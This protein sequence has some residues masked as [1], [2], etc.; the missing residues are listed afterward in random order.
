MQLDSI[1]FDVQP[2]KTDSL[3]EILSAL[4][5]DAVQRGICDDNFTA[6]DLFDTKLM[7]VFTPFPST[8]RKQFARLYSDSPV[9]ATDWYYHLSK[10]TNTSVLKELPETR[11]GHMTV[12]TARW[13]LQST[14]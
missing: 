10:V 2:V 8:I 11:N 1:D 9:K 13:I 7:G 5:D 12:N 4:I 6:Y 14:C 3:E